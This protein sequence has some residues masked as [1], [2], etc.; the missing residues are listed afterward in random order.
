MK[1]KWT[2]WVAGNNSTKSLGLIVVQQMIVALSTYFLAITAERL[3]TGRPFSDQLCLFLLSVVLPY[4]PGSLSLYYLKKSQ[5]DVLRNFSIS[6]SGQL[7]GNPRM[8]M[9]SEKKQSASALFTRE[10]PETLNDFTAY[11][12][13]NT[14]CGL[15]S[16]LSVFAVAAM[17]DVK[18]L[19]TFTGGLALSAWLIKK[20]D[21]KSQELGSLSETKKSLLGG[22]LWKMWDN[23]VLGNQI[24]F[25]AW[26]TGMKDLHQQSATAT[27]QSTR[28]HLESATLVSFINLLPS[29]LLAFYLAATNADHAQVAAL[30]VSLPRVFQMI[31]TGNQFLSGVAEFASYRGRIET[32][33]SLF[34]ATS[35][36]L[37]SRRITLPSI[38]V[39]N[40]ESDLGIEESFES[41]EALLTSLPTNG[42]ITLRGAN[43]AGKSSLL[44]ELK[45]RKADEAIYVPAKHDLILEAQ[46]SPGSTGQNAAA[47]L[48]RLTQAIPGKALFIDEWDANLDEMNISRLDAFIESAAL[49]SLVIE[50]RHR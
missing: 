17:I 2:E 45:R 15:N 5:Q 32:L 9:D 30:L 42:R 13:E 37:L 18:F 40:R 47:Y 48:Q 7:Y 16:L 29:V 31:N 3:A 46:T 25:N 36:D 23:V 10:G 41:I 26:S 24:N 27:I 6:A 50:V 33:N 34:D 28:Y 19:I 43:G 20:R 4:I 39:Q 49:N 11:L 1:T 21:R 44:L 38:R 35:E 12:H 22:W 14:S 8:W